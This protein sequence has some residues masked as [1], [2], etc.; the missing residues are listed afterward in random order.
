MPMQTREIPAAADKDT[1]SSKTTI[2]KIGT[3]AGP[4]PLAIGYTSDTSPC[5]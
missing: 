5:S 2:P 4:V 1:D 3:I